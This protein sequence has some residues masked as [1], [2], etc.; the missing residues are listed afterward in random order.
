MNWN[1]ARSEFP[2]LRNCTYLNSATYGQL[3][4][5]TQAAVAEHFA[6]RD[7]HACADFLTWFD[8]MDDLRTLIGG[9]I[10]CQ[11]SDIAFVSTAAAA[12]SL[13]MG[14][15][16]WQPGDR[17]VTLAN[18][19]PNQFYYARWLRSKGVELVEVTAIETL[20]ER[21]KA[22]V[23]STVN[24]MN[25]YRPDLVRIGQLARTAG[26]L[27]Y[28]DGTQSL[29]ALQFSVAEVQPDM[30]AVDSYKWLLSP[31]GAT[32]FFITPELRRLIPPAVIGWRSDRGWRDVDDLN[33]GIPRFPED[34]ERYE[35]GMLPFPSLY[36]LAESIRM[37]NELGPANVE[38][39]V[40]NLAAQTAAMLRSSGAEIRHENTNIVAAH[41]P[42]RDA[43]KLAIDLR[44]KGIL[45]AAR[46]GNLRVS[47]HF[48]N[49]EEDL[50]VLRRAL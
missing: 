25:G 39:R 33:H 40:L 28:V 32:F 44:A 21:T 14:G 30:Y 34:A 35:G 16:E 7:R 26:A 20:P 42:D 8:D 4:T 38:Y 50:D 19:F 45:V 48:Y 6:R 9:L 27:Y 10:D 22:V 47:P 2:S 23:L 41:W 24:Y 18:E 3:A 17:V 37:L 43:S 15:I 11:A 46:H 49:T 12:L 29:G 36:G 5:R 31:N 1:S 13:F